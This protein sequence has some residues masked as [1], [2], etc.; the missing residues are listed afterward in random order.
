MN[1]GLDDILD[2]CL[3]RITL[4]GDSIEQCLGSYPEQ[5]AELEPLLRASF[6]VI[7]ASS[8]K[9]RPEFKKAAKHRLLSALEA[10]ERKRAERRI[11][12]WGWQR[13]W[14]LALTVILALLLIGGG[15][16]TAS[17][18]SLPGDALYQVKTTTEK[19]QG[20]FTFGDEA[21]AS[22]H[23]KLA[24]RRLHELELLAERKRGIPES[25]LNVMHA[26]TDRA[27]EI[28]NRA[29]SAKEELVARLTGLT[30][31]QKAVL[32]KVIEKAS[33]QTKGRL[34]E[35]LKRSERAHGRAMYLKERVPEME[36]FKIIPRL[37][38]SKMVGAL[39]WWKY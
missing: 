3:D 6:S 10:E 39:L 37:H 22:F 29:R 27:I 23:I 19:V 21:K 8:I 14:A 30:S 11:P 34:Q 33:P 12:F 28:L 13:R 5:A 1:K 25:L 2:I 35:A 38:S 26:E 9:P 15:T 18:D 32:A 31:N 16:V 20:F 36:K 17:A 24:Q 7:E 4:K